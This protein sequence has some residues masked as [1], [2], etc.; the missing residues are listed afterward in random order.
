M[1]CALPFFFL[2]L[3]LVA[4]MPCACYDRPYPTR[5]IYVHD[6]PSLPEGRTPL[7]PKV[8]AEHVSR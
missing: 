3:Y 1:I 2:A 7:Q 4:F 5:V 6:T 8:P